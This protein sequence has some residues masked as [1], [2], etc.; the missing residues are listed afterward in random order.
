MTSREAHTGDRPREAFGVRAACCRFFSEYSEVAKTVRAPTKNDKLISIAINEPD[1]ACF[2]VALSLDVRKSAMNTLRSKTFLLSLLFAASN[3]FAGY[4]LHITKAKNWTESK[5][6]PISLKEWTGFVKADK[7]FRLVDAAEARNHTT[8]E[9]IKVQAEGMA[10]W[11]DPK[12]KSEC[13]F[14]YHAGEISVKSPNDKIITKMKAVAQ[15]LK[16]R[17][18]GDEG[19]EYR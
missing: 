14:Y 19:E 6:T 13:Y 10:I 17:V 16:A 1:T 8:G 12:D 11:T 7:E 4:D 5:K 9:F 2:E 15:K 3:A 18:I